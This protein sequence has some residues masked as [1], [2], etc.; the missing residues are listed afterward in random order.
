MERKFENRFGLFEVGNDD[1][2]FP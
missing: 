2:T 1:D